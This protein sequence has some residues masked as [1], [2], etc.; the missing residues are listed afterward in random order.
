MSSARDQLPVLII[1]GGIGGLCLAL[2]LGRRNI[3]V[4]LFEQ[5]QEF[6]E[7]G[8]GLQLS[9]NAVRRLKA[10]GVADDLAPLAGKPTKIVIHDGLD[11]NAI[12]EIPL[13]PEVVARYGEP[14]WVMARKDLQACLLAAVK[15]LPSVEI[16]TGHKFVTYTQNETSITAEMENGQSFQ[17]RLLVG[18]DGI[19]S[20]VRHMIDKQAVPSSTGFVAWRALV[21]DDKAPALFDAP[22]TQVW[23]GPDSH[24]V[25][26]RVSGE[27]Q[28]N[29]V[30]VTRGEA[31]P[32]TWAEALPKEQ[33]FE[34]LRPWHKPVRKAVMEIDDW[35]AWP[36]MILRPFKPWHKRRIVLLG[37]AAHAVVPFLA[38]GAALA[39]E[40]AALLGR[41]IEQHPDEPLSVPELY[42]SQRFDRCQKVLSKS[43]T[44]GHV[45]HAKKGY[46]SVRNFGL[47]RLTP[48]WLLKQYDWLY[49][50]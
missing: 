21:D 40:D 34:H 27:T 50:Y 29:L 2:E 16:F 38:Q 18:A 41:L 39:I 3:P 9:P 8:A 20:R 6:E 22:F 10:L 1:G 37:D 36:L 17:G 11:G 43:I 49:Q 28:H 12:N 48:S 5:A 15:A 46:R 45:Y 32:R 25:H 13:G 33:L 14:Y 42:Q 23:L 35:I 7:F 31:K 30:G 4:S 19:W 47:R 26:Y 24:L 44:N